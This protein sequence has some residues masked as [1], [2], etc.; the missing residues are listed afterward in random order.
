MNDW[1]MILLG[2]I[3]VMVAL[4]AYTASVVRRGRVLGRQVPDAEKPWL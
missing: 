4:A 2:W 3:V 1:P